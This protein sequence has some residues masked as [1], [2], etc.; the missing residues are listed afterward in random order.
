MAPTSQIVAAEVSHA[1]DLV[2][3][4]AQAFSWGDTLSHLGVFFD[5]PG[6][7]TRQHILKCHNVHPHEILKRLR[8]CRQKLLK[9]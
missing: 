3:D 9:Q 2:E 8:V 1:P 4:K 6:F 5:E 7:N